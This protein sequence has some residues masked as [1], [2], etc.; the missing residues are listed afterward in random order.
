L[1]RVRRAVLLSLGVLLGGGAYAAR[2]ADPAAIR[3]ALTR[4]FQRIPHPQTE[5]SAYVIDLDSAGVVYDARGDEPL[6]PASTLKV[7]TLVAAQVVLG[8]D[9]PF[10]TVLA[11]DGRNLYLIGGGDP[12]LGD[13]RLAEANGGSVTSVF[14]A[15]ADRLAQAGLSEFPGTLV[16]DASIFD[17]E[18]V[19]PT[20]EAEDLT[21]WYAAAVA[22]LNFNDNCVDITALPGPR[23]GDRVRLDVVP[24]CD[25]IRVDNRCVT[26]SGTPILHRSPGEATFVISGRCSR[27]WSFPAVS[28]PDPVG[29]GASALQKVLR[30]KGIAFGS[31]EV[32]R[33]VVRRPD[34]GLPE[35]VM[36]LARHQTPMADVFLRIGKDSQNLF[37]ECLLKRTGI[38]WAR[39]RG[40][41]SPAAPRGSWSLGQSA[42][43]DTVRRMGIET[44]GL[45]IADGSGL[46]RAS[47]CSARQLAELLRWADRRAEG[48]V[49]REC[50]SI[51]GVDG[52]LRRRLTDL[53]ATV[54]AKTGTMRGVRCLCG[55]VESARGRYAFAVLFN[56]Y[57][58]PSTPYRE[59]QDAVC[60]ILAGDAS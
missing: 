52:S 1:A 26:G 31:P 12:G 54:A 41:G 37:A 51:A 47:R 6:I 59:L 11:T 30:S 19:H 34:G 3:D 29:L 25:L 40:G 44:E 2:G 17:E 38:E 43:L 15:W 55:Y 42:V 35:G 4:V 10:E 13:P 36:E 7:F 27:K 60:R 8:M 57:P 22:G 32:V 46:S 33:R 45:T 39:R 28:H 49:L 16:V 14:E 24:D 23:A 9:A 48:T 18:W 5:W 58:G 50:L 56:G 21:K 53:S 20:W